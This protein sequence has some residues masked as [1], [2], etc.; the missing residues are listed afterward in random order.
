M[1]VRARVAELHG[2]PE[3]LQSELREICQDMP[4]NFRYYR[5][6]VMLGIKDATKQSEK[7]CYTVAKTMFEAAFAGEKYS[8]YFAEIEREQNKPSICFSKRK[9]TCCV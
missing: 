2:E 1:A 5:R 9:C 7:K 6:D 4:K 8:E 3:R